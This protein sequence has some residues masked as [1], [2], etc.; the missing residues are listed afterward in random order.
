MRTTE[1]GSNFQMTIRCPLFIDRFVALRVANYEKSVDNWGNYSS[2][3][4]MLY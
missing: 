1:N 2:M 4:L 3:Y